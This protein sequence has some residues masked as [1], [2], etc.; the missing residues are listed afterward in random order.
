MFQFKRLRERLYELR[1]DNQHEMCMSFMRYQEYYE[2]PRYTNRKFTWA[3]YMS[4]YAKFQN[5]D[6]DFSYA[7]DWAGFNIPAHIIAQVRDKG[8]D[9]PNHYDSLMHAVYGII[10]SECD[11]AYL[12]GV[13]AAQKGLD[14]H[15][16]THA[17][18]YIDCSYRNECLGLI[19]QAHPSLVNEMKK[20]LFARGYTEVTVM[21]EIQAYLTTGGEKMFDGLQAELDFKEL[22][23]G[24]KKAHAYSYPIFTKDIS[25]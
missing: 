12:V 11:D 8:I 21:D 5:K 19:D 15:E 17:M 14:K 25:E 16:T 22:K 20:C 10:S 6:G 24:L 2:S 4:W 18:F 7:R 23:R 1:F 9:D 13:K 3:E